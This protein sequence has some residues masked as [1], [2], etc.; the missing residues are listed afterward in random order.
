MLISNLKFS[1]RQ[2]KGMPQTVDCTSYRSSTVRLKRTVK[3]S[4]KCCL[5]V[6]HCFV[7]LANPFPQYVPT[8]MHVRVAIHGTNHYIIQNTMT[9]IHAVL[10]RFKQTE[11]KVLLCVT[12]KEELRSLCIQQ[13]TPHFK[14]Y[15]SAL[16]AKFNIERG[17]MNMKTDQLLNSIVSI[18]KQF[19]PSCTDEFL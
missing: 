12:A 13:G 15:Y 3:I 17:K 18:H 19:G 14:K 7:F 8:V 11:F 9:Q 16:C 10:D 5:S 2:H 6:R 4:T 1:L